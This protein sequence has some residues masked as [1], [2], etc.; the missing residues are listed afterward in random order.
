V[1]VG[2]ENFK[3]VPDSCR[4]CFYWQ[5]TGDFSGKDMTKEME[6]KRKDWFLQMENKFGCSGGSIAYYNNTPVGFVQ[7]A[8]A[9]H[10]PNIKE[11]PSGPPSEDAAF[12]ACLYIPKKENRKK[13]MGTL[14][15]KTG[16]S[17]LKQLGFKAVETFARKSSPENPS[18]PLGFYLKNG[19]KIKRDDNDF[20]LVRF[21]LK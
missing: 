18:G 21:E 16:L 10:F 8:S 12:L 13:G 20:P 4:R 17:Q 1:V 11:Y 3:D 15:L 6:D 2:R 9:K 7:C 19:F 14:I 5:T